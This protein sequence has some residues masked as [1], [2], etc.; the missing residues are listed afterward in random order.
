[1]L[2]WSTASLLLLPCE[3]PPPPEGLP[4]PASLP[5]ELPFPAPFA[6][7]PWPPPFP[8]L[9]GDCPPACQPPPCEECSPVGHVLLSPLFPAL[10]LSPS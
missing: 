8:S 2:S 9:P 5:G 4:P 6:P 1:M 10:L 3:F 7:V